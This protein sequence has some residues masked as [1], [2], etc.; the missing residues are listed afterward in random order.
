M[1]CLIEH[2]THVSRLS[3]PSIQPRPR[4]PAN[5]DTAVLEGTNP[6]ERNRDPALEPGRNR[7]STP[8][9]PVSLAP[10]L[11][12][13]AQLKQYAKDSFEMEE[14]GQPLQTPTNHSSGLQSHQL[15]ALR[16]ALP[17]LLCRPWHDKS[18]QALRGVPILV[19]HA[20]SPS[21]PRIQ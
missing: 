13:L 12:L 3:S 4:S 16:L 21:P 5:R 17:L 8:E 2:L 20:E 14:V 10:Q 19:L 9:K 11:P 7:T 18:Q 6:Q 15:L 1:Y